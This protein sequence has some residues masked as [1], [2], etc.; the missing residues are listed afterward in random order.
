MITIDELVELTKEVD[1]ED[2]IDWAMLNIDEND[3]IRLIAADVLEM[4]HEWS[5]SDEKEIIMLVT[6]TKLILE[7]FCL[8]LK[9]HGKENNVN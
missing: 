5:L 6:I 7:N 9:L 8:N 4:F 3:A 2:S 1:G